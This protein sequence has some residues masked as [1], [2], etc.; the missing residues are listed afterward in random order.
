MAGA[1]GTGSLPIPAAVAAT[2]R[3]PLSDAGLGP[4]KNV[5]ELVVDAA[6]G[7]HLL[8][9][10]GMAAS[11]PAST[12]KIATAA[13]ALTVL[14]PQTRL[15]TTVVGA[16]P[17]KGVVTGNL[18]LLGGG[19]PTLTTAT[20]GLAGRVSMSAIAKTLIAGGV[21]RVTGSVVG[22][23]SLFTG[24]GT[25]PGWHAS[26][27]TDGSVA[28][29]S[30]LEVDGGRYS[31]SPEPAPRVAS[32]PT[33]AA[34]DLTAALRLAHVT[35][36]GEGTSASTGR[37]AGDT[38]LAAL[39]GPPV[40]TL[41]HQMLTYSDNDL[42]ESL[43][44]LVSLKVGGA[45][46]FAGAASAVE[47]VDA[48]AG[49]PLTGAALQDTSGLSTLDRIPPADLVAILR[50]AVLGGHPELRPLA[51]GLPIS[52]RTGTLKDRYQV[53]PA[54]AAV[55]KVHAKTGALSGVSTEDGWLL[56]SGGRLLVFAFGSDDTAS[57]PL[58]E[59]AL[60]RAAAALGSLR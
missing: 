8:D 32:P 35:V 59:A 18:V 11:P 20:T 54:K 46:D 38:V 10:G 51:L 23:G 44:R 28:P 60:D 9:R 27:V 55:G 33:T 7:A 30:A 13:A 39:H 42:A 41:V 5:H 52:G 29:V 36:G 57:R 48:R 34:V 37:P 58:A 25:A 45:A 24:P 22:D 15:G 40:A 1:D 56:D 26:Y 49:L 3:A 19:D 12:I 47:Q 50:A 53:A 43:G 16:V 6:T 14:G 21:K 2:V 31:P 4:A 17:I